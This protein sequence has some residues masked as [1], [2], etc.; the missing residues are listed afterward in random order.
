[1]QFAQ[2]KRREFIV[3]LGGAAVAACAQQQR[4]ELPTIGLL[5]SSSPVEYR[6]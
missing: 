6:V 2:L 3:L 4:C 1:M 5:G